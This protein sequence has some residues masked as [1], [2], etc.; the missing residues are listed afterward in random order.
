[1]HQSRECTL[2]ASHFMVQLLLIDNIRF[3]HFYFLSAAA[4]VRRGRLVPRDRRQGLV[5]VKTHKM[6]GLGPRPLL[7]VTCKHLYWVINQPHHPS[8]SLS[9]SVSPSK[10]LF[11]RITL[12]LCSCVG[13]AC[14]PFLIKLPVA[15][16]E[17]CAGEIRDSV[18][19]R[20]GGLRGFAG[21]GEDEK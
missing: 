20:R 14:Y 5:D 16:E 19:A 10:H 9:P 18:S 1:M 4:H 15:A 6:F 13:A 12:W 11:P 17:L 7:S 8:F 21:G 3:F 2:F